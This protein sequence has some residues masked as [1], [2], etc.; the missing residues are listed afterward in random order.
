MSQI[1]N[2]TIFLA[3]YYYLRL[4]NKSPDF[5]A[6]LKY[7]TT[8][9]G[10]RKTPVF[11]TDYRPQVKFPFSNMQ[12]SGQQTFLDKDIVYP[13]DTVTAEIAIIATDFSK[14]N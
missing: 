5:I 13:G 10:G 2:V 6:E 1:L 11:K 14:I 9:E 8:E 12:T 3:G 7:R 4:M